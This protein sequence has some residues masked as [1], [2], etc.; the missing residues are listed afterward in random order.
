MRDVGL[1]P[2]GKGEVGPRNTVT[3]AQWDVHFTKSKKAA[4][5]PYCPRTPGS[6]PPITSIYPFTSYEGH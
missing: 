5:V 3:L 4:T 2:E 1:R 6:C